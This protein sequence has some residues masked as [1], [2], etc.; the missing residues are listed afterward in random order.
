[1]APL[2]H[3]ATPP[4]AHSGSRVRGV[5]FRYLQL[6]Q[7]ELQSAEATMKNKAQRHAKELEERRLGPQKERE[8]LLKQLEADKVSRKDR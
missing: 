3:N 1:M 4:W 8:W 6:A 2:W 7:Q 5:C